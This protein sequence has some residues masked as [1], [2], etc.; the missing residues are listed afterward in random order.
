MNKSL[1]KKVQEWVEETYSNADHLL[2]TGYWVK[3]LYPKASDSLIIA[4][5]SHDIE[6]AFK[7]GRNSPSPEMKG[8]IWDDP[9]YDKWHSE[10][11]AKLV[12]KFLEREK[13]ALHLIKE[14]SKLISHHEHGGW[15]EADILKDADSLSFLEINVDFFIS[16]IGKDLT[17]DEVREK[18]DL[19]FNRIE[20]ETAKKIAIPLYEK[21]IEKLSKVKD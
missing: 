11:S 3:K 9:V 8:A 18:F 1:I 12:I 15:K 14:V 16:R 10:R 20:S 13:A 5:I 21:A 19:M 7:E 4:A 17:R 6:R 2:R